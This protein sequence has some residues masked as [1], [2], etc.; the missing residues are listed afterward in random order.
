MKIKKA[1]GT[2]QFL[3]MIFLIIGLL[4]IV[5]GFVTAGAQRDFQNHAEKTT[6]VITDIDTT[7]TRSG[8]DK[9]TSHTAYVS[10]KVDGKRYEE[11]LNY[12]SS[13]MRIGD[14]IEVYYDSDN[15]KDVRAKSIGLT[16]P[17][18]IFGG[19][20]SLIGGIFVAINMKS[21]IE[22]KRLLAKGDRLTGTII[23]VVPQTNV[24]INGHNPFKVECEVYDPING[25][26]YLYSS[27]AVM[28]DLSYLIGNQIDVY[29]DQNN[30]NLSYVDLKSID[31]NASLG[32]NVYDF[33]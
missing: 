12:Y 29:V 6:A 5:S 15:P 32:N 18:Y 7:I 10:Y 8:N 19:I 2:T 9:K 25:A 22:K 33:R 27:E 21:F 14:K 28:N 30:K 26:K 20:F 23:N 1:S 13:T 24:R 11:A 4:I 3:G 16:L 17:L 31:T